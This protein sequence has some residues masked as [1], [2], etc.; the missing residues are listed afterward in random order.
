MWRRI[1]GGRSMTAHIFPSRRLLIGSITMLAALM[2]YVGVYSRNE[3]KIRQL[4]RELALMQL[5][6][7][8]DSHAILTDRYHS[9]G[10]VKFESRRMGNDR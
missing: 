8:D 1:P 4:D 3:Q 5:R 9:V 10:D 6:S 7:L 2:L